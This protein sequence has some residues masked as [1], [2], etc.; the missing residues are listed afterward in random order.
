MAKDP[1][2]GQ[3]RGLDLR[4]AIRILQHSGRP[5]PTESGADPE[6][7]LQA[8]IDD[9]CD[10]SIHDGL[11]GLMNARFFHAA[12]DREVDRSYRTGRSCALLLLD[13][14][15]FKHVNDNYGH[16]A[17]DGVLQALARQL[18]ISL[19]VMDTAARIGGEEFAVILP[20]CSP[21]DAIRASTRIHG[22]ISPLKVPLAAAS[23]EI[24]VSGGL[25]WTD[26]RTVTTASMLL[27]QADQEM[28]RAKHSGRR[29]LCHPPVVVTEVSIEERKA[30]QF[31]HTQEEP[32]GS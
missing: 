10:L 8:L 11:T 23:V 2:S 21:E 25:V 4:R 15:H 19:R 28:Y 7:Q 20:E 16:P 5:D 17:G 9:L 30:F 12:L 18:R 6:I 32:H 27:S 29:I 3:F 14:D 22:S 26:P 1:A 24:T 13:I 31:G